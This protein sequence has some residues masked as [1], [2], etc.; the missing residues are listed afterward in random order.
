MGKTP[1]IA[2]FKLLER[3]NRETVY[4]ALVGRKLTTSEDSLAALL[5]GLH[6]GTD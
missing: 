3:Q 4:N 2:K 1:W 5:A 6:K